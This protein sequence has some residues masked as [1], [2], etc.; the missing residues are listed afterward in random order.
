VN[1]WCEKVDWIR[2]AHDN[3]ITDSC[4]HCAGSSRF[5]ANE[6]VWQSSSYQFVLLTYLPDGCELARDS[7]TDPDARV[8]ANTQL[9]EESPI[10]FHLWALCLY[11]S[12]QLLKLFVYTYVFFAVSGGRAEGREVHG[13]EGRQRAVVGSGDGCVS[14]VLWYRVAL[15]WSADCL[16]ACLRVVTRMY[17]AW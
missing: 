7:T 6:Y 13:W 10:P 4:K 11:P 14:A 2:P 5:I 16:P 8:L 3:P 9:V 1:K 12:Q 15:R 17:S